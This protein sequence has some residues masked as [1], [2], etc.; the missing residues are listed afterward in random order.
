MAQEAIDLLISIDRTLKILAGLISPLVQQAKAAQPKAIASDHDLD[1]KY[2]DP[3]VKFM[4]RDWADAPFKGYHFSECPAELLDLLAETLDYF[5]GQSEAK[6]EL[7]NAGKP[8]APYKR[9]D[10]ARARG[11]AKRVRNGGG[12]AAS[13]QVDGTAPSDADAWAA[14]DDDIPF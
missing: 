1:S 5:A 12:R 7:T 11:W 6:N 4:P 3:I 8:V 2:G 9:A 13:A 14:G 10:A